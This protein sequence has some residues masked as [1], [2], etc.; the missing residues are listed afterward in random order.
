MLGLRAGEYGPMQVRG[1]LRGTMC[2][3]CLKEIL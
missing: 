2:N 3:F 1:G